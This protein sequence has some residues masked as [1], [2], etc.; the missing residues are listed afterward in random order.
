M[1]S[2][3]GLF[4][5]EIVLAFLLTGDWFEM[6]EPTLDIIRLEDV[7]MPIGLFFL[8]C[9]CCL[10]N[11]VLTSLILVARDRS[12]L[13]RFFL[14]PDRLVPEIDFDDESSTLSPLCRVL[15]ANGFSSLSFLSKI[16]LQSSLSF[17]NSFCLN[18]ESN[19][20][21]VGLFSVS[22]DTGSSVWAK[23]DPNL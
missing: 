15:K 1:L 8:C 20:L 5:A 17:A 21:A 11:S 2:T 4:V 19:R 9:V 12:P 23:G 16:G 18:F 6:R 14:V 10:S 22:S 13:P 3:V 7:C